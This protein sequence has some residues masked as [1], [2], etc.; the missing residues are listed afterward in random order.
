MIHKKRIFCDNN[1]FFGES[2]YIYLIAKIYFL[3]EINHNHIKITISE[4]ISILNIYSV[5]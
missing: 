5:F 3:I 2:I 4:N 1:M